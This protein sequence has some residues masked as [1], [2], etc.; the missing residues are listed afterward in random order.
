MGPHL[1]RI[2]VRPVSA[3][4]SASSA[5][6]RYPIDSTFNKLVARERLAFRGSRRHAS[7]DLRPIRPRSGPV[8]PHPTR[9]KGRPVSA[10]GASVRYPLSTLQQRNHMLRRYWRFRSIVRDSPLE[11]A[12][13]SALIEE[14][15]SMLD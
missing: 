11:L 8:G 6:V 4:V 5:S 2:K 9:I 14:A 1:T 12:Y 7:D 15:E 10:S 3:S 13:R